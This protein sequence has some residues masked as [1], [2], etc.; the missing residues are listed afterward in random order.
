MCGVPQG[1]KGRLT[2]LAPIAKTQKSAS[3]LGL[4]AGERAWIDRA[5]TRHCAIKIG[6][7]HCHY[8]WTVSRDARGHLKKSCPNRRKDVTVDFKW[9]NSGSL[10]SQLW[11]YLDYKAL[12]G[13][14]LQFSAFQ[15]KKQFSFRFLACDHSSGHRMAQHRIILI[16]GS[17]NSPWNKLSTDNP[18]VEFHPAAE[19]W[20]R[21]WWR[22]F[23]F[24]Q[25]ES[26]VIETP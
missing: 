11:F 24:F 25:R 23:V 13:F 14:C 22:W 4:G 21:A 9:R 20:C 2:C 19:K 1:F 8:F 7:M 3:T 26:P 15:G 6:E 17:R 5:I 10:A 18:F 12:R 16:F